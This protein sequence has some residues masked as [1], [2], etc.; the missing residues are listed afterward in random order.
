M[1]DLPDMRPNERIPWPFAIFIMLFGAPFMLVPFFFIGTAL[2]EG[3]T[4]LLLPVCFF[5]PPFFAAGAAVSSIG[6]TA[7]SGKLGRPT[8]IIGAP[9]SS[10][11]RPAG[12]AVSMTFGGNRSLLGPALIG[13]LLVPFFAVALFSA[14]AGLA[15][16]ISG[17]L[18][19]V[20]IA[21][22]AIPFGLIASS[23]LAGMLS[24][25]Y[26]EIDHKWDTL[27]YTE[28]LFRWR[29]HYEKR[30]VSEASCVREWTVTSTTT[31][32]D[33]NERTTETQRIRI[34]RD[35]LLE[36]VDWDLDISMLLHSNGISPQ[37]VAKALGV[38]YK[39][40]PPLDHVYVLDQDGKTGDPLIDADW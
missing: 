33:G 39:P 7:L 18:G 12:K 19:G 31:D 28:R 26:L 21:F 1:A 4:E 36:D 32:S 3:D 24:K 37:D 9:E 17:N 34:M 2:L 30:K 20:C 6:W 16:L 14:L 10:G 40:R 13:A 15:E 35:R 29:T 22:V 27:V 23:V 25:R 5:G 8:K 11:P 38:P